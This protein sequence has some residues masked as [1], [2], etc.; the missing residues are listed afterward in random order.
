MLGLFNYEISLF[1]IKLGCSHVMIHVNSLF[2]ARKQYK[3]HHVMYE[4][5]FLFAFTLIKTVDF[6]FRYLCHWFFVCVVMSEN[7]ATLVNGCF[8]I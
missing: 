5:I 7:L 6:Y 4:H 3:S 2:M 1:I 8:L